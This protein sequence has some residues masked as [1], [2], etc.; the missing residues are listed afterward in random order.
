[1]KNED[2]KVLVKVVT[3]EHYDGVT[4]AV[5]NVNL[6]SINF[7]TAQMKL[8]ERLACKDTDFKS[9]SFTNYVVDFLNLDEGEFESIEDYLILDGDCEIPGKV[10]EV[11]PME[12]IISNNSFFWAGFDKHV[13]VNGRVE[14]YMFDKSDLEEWDGRFNGLTWNQLSNLIANIPYKNRHD[15]VTILDSQNEFHGLQS[16]MNVVEE[17]DILDKECRFLK[18]I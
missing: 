9:L 2:L 18:V 11:V 16:R 1:M 6:S 8:A 17:T 15:S 7:I 12:L 3:S 13:G 4:H 14:T 5:I 10:V